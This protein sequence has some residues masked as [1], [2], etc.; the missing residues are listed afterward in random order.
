MHDD[1]L[2]LKLRRIAEQRIVDETMQ[3]L[4]VGVIDVA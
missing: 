2:E 3:F 4:A 1:E